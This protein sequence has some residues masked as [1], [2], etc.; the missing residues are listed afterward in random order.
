VNGAELRE[1]A[2]AFVSS[3]AGARPGEY[4][5]CPNGEIAF[6]ASCFAAL[7]LHAAGAL[8]RLEDGERRAWAEYLASFQ[9]PES[10][11]FLG[12]ELE[13]PLESPQHD[14]E[15]LSLHLT[16]H[17]LP[18]L[19]LLGARPAHP[20]RAA[21]RLLDRGELLAWL[22]RLDWRRAW[23]EGNELLFA[24][25]LLLHLREVEGRP[26][27]GPALELWFDWLDAHQDPRTGLWGTDRGADR[28]G[29]LF[30]AYHPLLVYHYCARPVPRAERI[31]DTALALQHPDGGFAPGGGGGACEDLDAIDVLVNLHRR[32][33]HR[34]RAVRRALEGAL[35]SVLSR[36]RPDGGFVY[37]R[38]EP[39]VPMGMRRS[40]A[41]ADTSHLFPTWFA[42]HSAALAGGLL[43]SHPMAAPGWD[44]N[45]TCSMGWHD[46]TAFAPPRPDPLRD[47]GLEGWER[48]PRWLRHGARR[49]SGRAQRLA[50]SARRRLLQA[51]RTAR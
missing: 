8:A 33:G 17:A 14:R 4:R 49:A 46:P 40:A 27:A 39:F 22:E 44:F 38:G 5:S 32:T 16:C 25:Q 34:P 48:L 19:A 42:L 50:G 24:A 2:V 28:H 7:A 29:A 6:E 12:P 11:L 15:H 26:E 45:P 1:R 3:L 31:L 36:R 9:D 23:R 10:G 13:G 37:R 41:P 20:L 30:G 43:P 18:A 47:R 21:R 35:A 51:R